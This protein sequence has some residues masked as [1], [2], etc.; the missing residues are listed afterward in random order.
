M[1]NTEI[2]ISTFIHIVIFVLLIIIVSVQLILVWKR[3]DRIFYL[4]FLGL[5]IAGLLYNIVEG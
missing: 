5:V 1:F 4:K 2:C 3:R